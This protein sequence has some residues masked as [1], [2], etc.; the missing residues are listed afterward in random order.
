ML[1]EIH[2]SIFCNA[3]EKFEFDKINYMAH[4]IFLNLHTL[5]LTWCGLDN[6]EALRWI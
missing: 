2:G 3:S 6:I 5:I 1:L 4:I